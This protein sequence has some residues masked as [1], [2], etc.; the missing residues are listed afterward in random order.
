MYHQAIER[1]TMR[2]PRN[3]AASAG[4]WSAQHRKTAIIGWILFVVLAFGGGKMIGTEKMTKA[5]SGVGQSG[6]A[7]KLYDGAYP[8]AVHESV[9]IQ[10]KTLT[11]DSAAYRAVVDDISRRVGAVKNVTNITGP[12]G[13]GD[14]RGADLQG[15]ALRARQLRD[16]R[17]L[18]RGQPDAQAAGRPDRRADRRPRSSPIRTSTSSSSA[19]RAPRTRS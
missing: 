13:S 4:R 2:K 10:S 18:R 7:T 12:Y 1:E 14:Q 3:L 6:Q 17:R 16:P 8:K 9:L 15:R 11:S 5:E 19:M